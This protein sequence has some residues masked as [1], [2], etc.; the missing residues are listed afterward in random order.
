MKVLHILNSIEYSGA[1]MMI[2]NSLD[3]FKKKK[4]FFLHLFK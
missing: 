4:F 1:E 3:D 2:L